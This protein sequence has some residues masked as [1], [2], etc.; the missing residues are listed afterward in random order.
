MALQKFR[1]EKAVRQALDRAVELNLMKTQTLS[2]AAHDLR[3]PLT[4]ILGSSEILKYLGDRLS[5]EKK[6]QYFDRIKTSVINMNV[7]IDELLLANQLE[8]GRLPFNPQPLN[9]AAFCHMSIDRV[10]ATAGSQH[11]LTFDISVE[12]RTTSICLDEILLRHI[13]ANLLSNAVKYSPDGGTVQLEVSL[14][15]DRVQFCI[16][17]EGIGIPASDV[18][19]LF[20]MFTRAE[21]VGDIAG[22]GLGL[23]I[24]KQSVDLHG[25]SIAVE[26]TEGMGTTFIVT[27]PNCDRQTVSVE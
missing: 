2:M 18:P 27:L 5:P 15:G 14:A 6:A 4:S 9:L 7:L 11:C 21:N 10:R 13:L 8:T 3:N 1:S 24:V 23:H 20:E 12:V 16:S 19:H 17:D 22:T 26:S 25:G